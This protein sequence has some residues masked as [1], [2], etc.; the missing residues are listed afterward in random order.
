MIK[1]AFKVTA[2]NQ[3]IQQVTLPAGIYTYQCNVLNPTDT[4]TFGLLTESGVWNYYEV[5]VTE[6]AWVHRAK[7]EFKTEEAV[8]AFSLCS[9]NAS[10]SN[11]VYVQNPILAE[12]AEFSGIATRSLVE[13]I[14][15]LENGLVAENCTASLSEGVLSI[16][17]ITADKGKV[18]LSI[19]EETSIISTQVLFEKGLTPAQ[20]SKL[21]A[22]SKGMTVIEGGYIQS[23]LVEL[24]NPEEDVTTAGSSGIDKDSTGVIPDGKM[25]AFWAGGT[26]E[27][28]TDNA[29]K[30]IVRHDGSV[31]FTEAEIEGRI[32]GSTF[33]SKDVGGNMIS[34]MNIAG[35]GAYIQYYPSGKKMMELNGGVITYYENDEDNTVLWT[36]GRAGVIISGNID[37]WQVITLTETTE[38][39]SG[40]KQP[41]IDGVQWR[42]FVPGSPSSWDSYRGLTITND[43][44]NYDNPSNIPEVAYIPNGWYTISGS[45]PMIVDEGYYREV[46]YYQSG[47]KTNST[48]IITF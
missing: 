40:I 5:E 10:V 28:A 25:P 16:S 8:T 20:S 27:D 32:T 21:E 31:K 3:Y 22:I 6:G 26:Y 48:K 47:Y 24:G 15:E 19:T 33:A 14:T 12:R 43:S 46:V 35:D 18:V 42:V 2:N 34:S 39:G 37:R 13:Y 7:L 1:K 11:P 36:L 23:N 29:A 41:Y 17:N 45:A 38:L 9:A 44:F 30:A 4:Y